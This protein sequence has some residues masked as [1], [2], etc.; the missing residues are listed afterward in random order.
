MRTIE[1]HIAAIQCQRVQVRNVEPIKDIL[2]QKLNLRK[3]E[4]ISDLYSIL[5][6]NRSNSFWIVD[7]EQ[8]VV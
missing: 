1:T 7:S 4:E 3:I 6:S 2:M 5:G 8:V